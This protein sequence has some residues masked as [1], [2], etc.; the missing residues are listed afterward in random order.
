MCKKTITVLGSTGII[1]CKTIELLLSNAEKYSVQ[2]L[3]AYRNVELLAYQARKLSA[4]LAVIADAKLYIKLKDLLSD[5]P[6]KVAAGTESL[7]LAA[8]MHSQ[9]IMVGIT[10]IVA[11][12]PL[13]L[14]IQQPQRIIALANKEGLVCAGD[15]LLKA[16]K[17][18]QSKI[19]PVDSEN[20]AIFQIIDEEV[21]NIT[22]TASGGPFHSFTA[23]QLQ[24]VSPQEALKHPVWP[25]GKKISIDSATMM[26]KVFEV[27]AAHHL[28][29]L[30]Y[31]KI[32]ILIHPQ[33][34][35]H[36]LVAYKD[37]S[38]IALLSTSDMSIPIAYA[39]SWPKRI[40][41]QKYL[42]LT[43]L[44]Q[45][46]F[47][48]ADRQQFTAL[49]FLQHSLT[50]AQHIAM[51]AANEIAVEA[52]LSYK[53]SFLD[54]VEII[55]EIITQFSHYKICSL[56]NILDCNIEVCERTLLLI[57]SKFQK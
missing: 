32:N 6:I 7:L 8:Q 35:V 38:N 5:T 45:L 56:K 57:K 10:G 47:Y 28:F 25:M 23:K 4:K 43:K 26:N 22:L 19:I 34:I 12:Q 40:S 55:S 53:I 11:L 27:I 31:N 17:K 24:Q 15:L 13:M 49:R 30:E 16:Q 21:T 50:K 52:F 48:K 37:N 46:T 39:L 41:S 18:A 3:T 1:G 44:E 20:N 29:A 14:A 36:G 9:W 51:N 54:I 42:D 33:A 2:A